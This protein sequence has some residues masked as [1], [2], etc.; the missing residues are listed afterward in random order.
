[1]LSI[2]SEGGRRLEGKRSLTNKYEQ[3]ETVRFNNKPTWHY[4]FLKRVIDVLGSLI[5]IIL[6]IPVFLIISIIIKINEPTGKVLFAHNRKG[7]KGKN[8][9]MYKFRSMCMDAEQRL[10]EDEILFHRFINQGYK[11]SN[12][13][14]PRITKIG[15]FLRKTSLDELPQLFNVLKGEMSLVG[16]RPITRDELLEYGNQQNL[17]LSVKPGITGSWQVSGRSNVE[18]PERCELELNYAQN[19]NFI[20]DISILVRTFLVVFSGEG[21]H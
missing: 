1:M 2:K 18:Y 8:F 9:K 3:I 10:R 11:L 20:G 6:L 7:Q 21:A 13:E 5:G 19:A 15:R 4:L 12:E 16:P 17:F 14:D